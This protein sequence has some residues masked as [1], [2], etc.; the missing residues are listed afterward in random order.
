MRAETSLV[1]QRSGEVV[2][3]LER[4]AVNTRDLVVGQLVALALALEPLHAE[5]VQ[6]VLVGIAS[7]LADL[8]TRV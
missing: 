4:T 3:R 6:V 2:P 1:Q 5:E 7:Q 8:Q